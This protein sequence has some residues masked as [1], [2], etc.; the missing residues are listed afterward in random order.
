M[1]RPAFDWTIG[2]VTEAADNDCLQF[3]FVA[4]GCIGVWNEP[5][6]EPRGAAR[7][8]KAVLAGWAEMCQGHQVFKLLARVWQSLN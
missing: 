1:T 5:Q 4:C 7:R 8:A 6:D 3:V 2:G